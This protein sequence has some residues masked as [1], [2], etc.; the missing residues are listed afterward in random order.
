MT[1]YFYT[2]AEEK[3]LR[4]NAANYVNSL[5]MA[6]AFNAVFQSNRTAE[7]L[8]AKARRFGHKFGHSGG[9]Q[10]GFGSS[11][12]AAPIGAE[13][14]KG[15][16]LYVKVANKPLPKNFTTNELRENWV[17]KHRL[18]WERENGKIPKNG[19]VVFLD[20]DRSNFNANNL[21]CTSRKV[22]AFMMRNG[23]FSSNPEVTLTAIKWCELTMAINKVTKNN[24]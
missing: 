4:N 13:R 15:G 24:S 8:R 19:I 5:E 14:W 7:S 2:P 17:A 10:A 20:G 11:V 16:Y 1:A 6:K 21:Y 18:L 22:T 23:W 9:K 12:T 3:W